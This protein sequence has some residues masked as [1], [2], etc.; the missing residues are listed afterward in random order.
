MPSQEVFARQSQ[1]YRD[2]VL[3]VGVRRLAV[4]AGHPMSW[5]RWVGSEGGVLG[6][7]SFGASA[8]APRL[9]EEFGLTAPGI[10]RAAKRLV[11]T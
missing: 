5:Y 9:F 1:E 11:A 8:P 4:E 10:V 6:M 3:P 7:E 2:R